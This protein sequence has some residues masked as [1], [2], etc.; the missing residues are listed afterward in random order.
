MLL[1]QALAF[2]IHEKKEESHTKVMNLKHQL[3]HGM[4]S[5]NYLRDYILYQLFKTYWIYLKNHGEKNDNLSV[6][7]YVKK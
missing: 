7:I 3:R 6:R 5:L 4:K 1:C 2:N